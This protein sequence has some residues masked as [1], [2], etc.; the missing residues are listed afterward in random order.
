[1]E[2]ISPTNV[3]VPKAEWQ[4][5]FM[6]IAYGAITYSYPFDVNLDECYGTLW[7]PS[8]IDTGPLTIME[9]WSKYDTL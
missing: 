1:M 7:N 3:N 4:N 5:V 6:E 8:G 2:G 9:Q